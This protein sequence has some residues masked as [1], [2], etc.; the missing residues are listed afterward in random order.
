MK[1]S[2]KRNSNISSTDINKKFATTK[3]SP[4]SKINARIA[5]T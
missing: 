1:K 4:T 5:K 2:I 3:N